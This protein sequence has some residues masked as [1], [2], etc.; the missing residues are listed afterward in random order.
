M[1]NN[2]TDIPKITKIGT[3]YSTTWAS[4]SSM[5]WKLLDITNGKAYLLC[6][7]GKII[8]TDVNTLRVPKP[9]KNGQ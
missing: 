5:S 8:T 9:V 1:A 4:N 6:V 3:K 2:N 7:N